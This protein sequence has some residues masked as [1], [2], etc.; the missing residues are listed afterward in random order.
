MEVA[1]QNI[2]NPITDLTDMGFYEP[3]K[4]VQYGY[5]SWPEYDEK[6]LRPRKG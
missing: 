1:G 3:G 5:S 2:E 4:L 6:D